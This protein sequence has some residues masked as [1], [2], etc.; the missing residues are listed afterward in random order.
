LQQPSGTTYIPGSPGRELLSILG[1][2]SRPATPADRF[3]PH[4]VGSFPDVYRAYVRRA[5]SADGVSY[6]IVPARYDRAAVSPPARC[7]GLLV[8][9]LT[10]YIP[11]IPTA[12]R[13]PTREIGTAYIAYLRSLAREAPRDAI[14][15]VYVAGDGDGS[16]GQ[17]TLKGIQDGFATQNSLGTPMGTFSG[18]VPDGVATVTLDLPAIGRQPAHAVTTRVEGNVYV[19]HASGLSHSQVSP[20]V[21]WRSPDGRVLKR[22]S[23]SPA[24]NRAYVCKRSPV[25]CLLVSLLQES[26]SGS[27]SSPVRSAQPRIAGG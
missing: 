7:F 26:S 1:V 18:V 13:Q 5:S 21:I 24:A 8:A 10:R 9:A 19:V 16:S 22:M 20:T 11:K 15:L 14:Y 3:N 6:Y 4:G 12:L 17:W 25:A 23:T 27:G 2:L